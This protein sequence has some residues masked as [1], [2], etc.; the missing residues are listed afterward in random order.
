M[1]KL[2]SIIIIT[3]FPFCIHAQKFSAGASAGLISV[4]SNTGINGNIYLAYHINDK[5]SLGVDGL[6]GEGEDELKTTAFLAYVEAGNTS[7]GV[8]PKQLSKI[9]RLQATLKMIADDNFSSLTS[10]AYSGNYYD[11]AHFI[12]DFK[13]FTGVSPKEFYSEN[14]KLS[15]LFLGKV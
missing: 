15:T 10:V 14:L 12:K 2:T 7:W 9:I 3:I 11:Q 6:L 8:S 4:D 5:I 13:E 1:K